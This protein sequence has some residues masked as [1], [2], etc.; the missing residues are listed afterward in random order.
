MVSRIIF[1]SYF[2]TKNKFLPYFQLIVLQLQFAGCSLQ[3]SSG[4]CFS[5]WFVFGCC[6]PQLYFIYIYLFVYI[7][8]SISASSYRYPILS[9]S[10]LSPSFFLA[11][12]SLYLSLSLLSSITIYCCPVFLAFASSLCCIVLLVL[13]LLRPPADALDESRV[14]IRLLLNHL[15]QQ[16]GGE[17]LGALDGQAQ[18]T[19][20]DKRGQDTEGT[21]HTEEYGVVVHLLH[22]VVLQQD[23]GMG[24][25][26]GPG[27][28]HLAGLGQ[29]WWHHLVDL[30]H[31]LEQL[32]FGQVLQ[33]ELALAGVAGI[34]LTEHSMTITRNDLKI[35]RD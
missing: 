31:Q 24:I 23:T 13:V 10:P 28:L 22:A 33:G 9:S 34:G 32:V 11:I 25:Y 3:F 7:Q 35:V 18:G 17:R 16:I 15:D 29:D 1:V 5:Y 19:I 6:S 2:T 21:G 20:P 26:I 4:F 30:R 27:V 14:R 12:L 8:L